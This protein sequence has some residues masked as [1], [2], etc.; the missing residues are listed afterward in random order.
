[1]HLLLVTDTHLKQ[2][3]RVNKFRKR[4]MRD[5]GITPEAA[6]HG[7]DFGFWF[8]WPWKSYTQKT[9]KFDLPVYAIHGNHED[10]D[11]VRSARANA[12]ENLRIFEPGG[13]IIE[14]WNE[15]KT[16]LCRVLGVGG[17]PCVD[18]PIVYYPFKAEDYL[19]AIKLWEKAGKPQIDVLLTHEVP[20]NVGPIGESFFGDPWQA[21]IPELRTLWETVRPRLLIAGHYHKIHVWEE[22]GLKLYALP[23]AAQGGA[24]LDTTDWRVHYFTPT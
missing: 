5:F 3:D 23:M 6:L 2:L 16:E 17:A 21:G 18:D 1:M 20:K 15:E 11:A 19:D 24:V 22:Q 12:I 13:E 8:E 7:G 14:I 10:P 4:L 9:S